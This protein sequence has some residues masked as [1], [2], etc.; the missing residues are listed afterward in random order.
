MQTE[1][2]LRFALPKAPRCALDGS[3]EPVF[4]LG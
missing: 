2:A 3:T 1:V 4:G